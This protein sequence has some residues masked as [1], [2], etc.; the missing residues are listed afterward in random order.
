M[1]C[2]QDLARKMTKFFLFLWLYWVSY[3]V[4]WSVLLSSMAATFLSIYIYVSNGMPTLSSDVLNALLEFGFFWFFILLNLMILVVI[5]RSVKHLFHRCYD[6]YTLKLLSCPKEG[7]QKPLE[8]IG[9]GDLLKVWRKFFMHLVW[10]VAFCVVMGVVFAKLF[11]DG[12]SVFSWFSIYHLYGFILLSA[13]FVLMRL[14]VVCKLVR[15]G[16]C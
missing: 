3:V 11:L 10:F 15:V 5:F 4:F 6:G 7:V 2:S 12:V 16:K 9:Y 14:S 1:R 8:V 13:Y